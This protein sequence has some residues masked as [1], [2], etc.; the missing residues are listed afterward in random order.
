MHLLRLLADGKYHSGEWLGQSLGVSRAAVWKQISTLR[1]KGVRIEVAPGKGYRL[2]EAVERWESDLLVEAMGLEARRLLASLRIEQ[3]TSS[4]NDVVVGML[5][6]TPQG[7][8]VC[9]AEEQTAG[10]G[11]RGRDWLSPWGK[12]F[13]CSVG[14]VFTEGL[15]VL[16]GLSLAVGV[17][18]V[19]AVSRL[20]IS[21]VQLKWPNDLEVG[22]AKLGGILIEVHAEAGGHC[23]VIVGVG[24]N[25]ALPAGAAKILGRP[26]TDLLTLTGAVV[27]RNRLGGMIIEELLLLLQRYPQ[28]GF[29]AVRAE[30]QALDAFMDA[31]VIV[32]GLAEVIEGTAQGV[33]EHGALKVLTSAGIMHL[34]AGEV[35]L[36]KKL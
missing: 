11:R 20:G 31:P 10:R 2:T 27:E 29:A 26:V 1:K 25:L 23:Q 35:S 24:L 30:W 16:E 9:I 15:T 12:N 19:R 13:Y 21:G 6:S 8:V 17:A 14:W 5:R 34:Q 36:R 32:T 7:G 3:T 4:T 18:V 28:Q 22:G 33:D